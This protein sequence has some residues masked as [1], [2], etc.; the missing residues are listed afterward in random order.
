MDQ[1]ALPLAAL[2]FALGLS[3]GVALAQDAPVMKSGRIL[4]ALTKD[5]RIDDDAARPGR[6]PARRHAVDLQVQFAFNSADLL[7]GG[8]RQLDELA[9]ALSDRS[10]ANDAFEITGHTDR[11]GD[12]E[13]NLRLSQERAAVVRN[14]LVTTHRVAP[15]RLRSA[16]LGFS[17]L[18]DPLNPTAAV[19]RRVEV[20]RVAAAAQPRPVTP[21]IAPAT[22]GRLV[23]TPQ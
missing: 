5:V 12:A 10:L 15:A 13:Y 23:P 16:G 14:Y 17:Q 20:R 2:V 21:A 18:A 1:R 22:G 8:Q 11:V 6:T 7:P 4:E 9:F 19:N 3:G